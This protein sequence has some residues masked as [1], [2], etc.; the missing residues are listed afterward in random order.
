MKWCKGQCGRELANGQFPIDGRGRFGRTCKACLRIKRRRRY[1]Y[2]RA[3]RARIGALHRAWYAR[4]ADRERGKQMVRDD[5][6]K[7][8]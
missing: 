5:A 6:R 1:G 8:A 2:D 7:A 3:F 4:N